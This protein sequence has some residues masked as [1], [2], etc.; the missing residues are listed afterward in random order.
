MH[1]TFYQASDFQLNRHYP[2]EYPAM[3]LQT[4]QCPRQVLPEYPQSP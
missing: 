3:R 2:F 4:E 1:E